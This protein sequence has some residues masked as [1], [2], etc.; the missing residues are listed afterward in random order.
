MNNQEADSPLFS[1][2]PV[3]QQSTPPV[4][5]VGLP[6]SGSSFLAH[7]LSTLDGWYVFDDLYLYEKVKTLNINGTLQSKQ[8]HS[9]VSFLG[10][11]VRARVKFEKGFLKP[12]CTWEDVDRMVEAVLETFKDRP[13]YWHQLLEEWLMRLALHH[14]CWR[15][16]YKTPKDFLHMDMLVD[17][18]PEIRF[19]FIRRDPRKMMASK[20]YVHKPNGDPREYHPIAYALYWKM[21]YEKVQRFIDKGRAPVYAV[22]FEEL[23]VDPNGVAQQLADFLGTNVSGSVPIKG[24]NT[25]FDS[26]KRQ[27]ITETEKWICEHLVGESMEKAGYTIGEVSPKFQ[28][29]GDLLGT[30]IQFSQHQ[31]RRAL[32][33]PRKR[34]AVASYLQGLLGKK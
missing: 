19:I 2:T 28:D 30:S 7:V 1:R 25:S 33:N 5:V 23:V 6:R 20:K 9:L 4:V 12:Q 14:G 34:V 26:G 8:L 11:T 21:A 32:T 15:W 10:W 22:K 29:L 24:K 13:V 16:G 27:D 31:M 3:V 18:F 17:L